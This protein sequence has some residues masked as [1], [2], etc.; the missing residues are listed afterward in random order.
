METVVTE[1]GKLPYCQ[2]QPCSRHSYG[3]HAIQSWRKSKNPTTKKRKRLMS[4][5]FLPIFFFLNKNESSS[6][7]VKHNLTSKFS[8]TWSEKS[9][10]QHAFTTSIDLAYFVIQ[11]GIQKSNL[12]KTRLTIIV[13]KKK[14]THTVDLVW[15]WLILRV[16]LILSPLNTLLQ[17]IYWW[18]EY[19]LT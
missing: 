18:L 13:K 1:K 15:Y 5:T 17:F 19:L 12:N 6:P 3:Q 16:K 4:L 2:G 11:T 9:E 10:I 7:Q 8:G 14:H